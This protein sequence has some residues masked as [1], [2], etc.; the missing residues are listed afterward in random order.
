MSIKLSRLFT[1]SFLIGIVLL[2]FGCHPNLDSKEIASS[3]NNVSSFCPFGICKGINP[4]IL[5]YSK[6]MESLHMNEYSA[7][8]VLP[9]KP[10]VNGDTFVGDLFVD[11]DYNVLYTKKREF[12]LSR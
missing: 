7:T 12:A 1:L 2:Q 5:Y 9:P 4:S 10:F 8:S 6:E 3:E 11:I